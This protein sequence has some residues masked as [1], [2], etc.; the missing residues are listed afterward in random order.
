GSLPVSE[1]QVTRTSSGPTT[2]FLTTLTYYLDTTTVDG[3]P[4][5]YTVQAIDDTGNLTGVHISVATASMPVT[6]ASSN[7]NPPVTVTAKATSPSTIRL[8]WTQGNYQG[9]V[10]SYYNV[11]RSTS[12]TEFVAATPYAKVYNSAFNPATI[13]ND[14]GLSPNTTYYYVVRSYDLI[15]LKESLNSNHAFDTTPAPIAGIPPVTVSQMAF[16]A[17]I[18]LPLTGQKLGIYYVVPN[19]GSVE[20]DIYNISGNLIQTLTPGQGTANVQQNTT[21]DGKDR[22]GN[23][24]ASG[25]YLL[26]IKSPGF[27]QIKKVAVVK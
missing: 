14:T 22:N 27:H 26:E 12:F 17:N 16:D 18:L 6:A 23:T 5:T 1:Y 7:V 19:T 15:G 4:V 20:I 25:L 2:T 24:V 13:F 9:R 8:T 10:I 3:A 21:W 11:Y